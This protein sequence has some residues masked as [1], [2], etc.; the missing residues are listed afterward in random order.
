[1]WHTIATTSQ[2]CFSCK[3]WPPRPDRW[4]CWKQW[5]ATLW[6][7]TM[8]ATHW[9]K[10]RWGESGHWLAVSWASLL[11]RLEP[12]CPQTALF[13]HGRSGMLPGPSVVCLWFEDR[14]HMSW[15]AARSLMVSCA[16]LGNPCLGTS[17]LETIKQIPSG[18]GLLCWENQSIRTATCCLMDSQW[19]SAEVSGVWLR[20]GDPTWFSHQ[21][22]ML[23]MAIQFWL[24]GKDLDVP[25]MP[26]QDNPLY[27]KDAADVLEYA[28][29][30]KRRKEEEFAMSQNDPLALREVQQKKFSV[31]AA[32]M[33]RPEANLASGSGGASSSASVALCWPRS[34]R[35]TDTATGV[36]GDWQ[37]KRLSKYQT[38][39]TSSWG[40]VCKTCQSRRCQEAENQ[41]NQARVWKPLDSSEAQVQWVLHHGWLHHRL[42][43]WWGLQ[44][45]RV[46]EWRRWDQ[47]PRSAL[48]R[49][50]H[51]QRAQLQPWR[52][53]RW[54]SWRWESW[55][56][57]MS[58]KVRSLASSLQ[59]L[60]ETGDSR[61]MTMVLANVS[62]A[63]WGAAG[64]WQESLQTPRGQIRFHLL[65]GHTQATCFTWTIWLWNSL[66]RT[67]MFPTNPFLDARTWRMHFCAWSRKSQ[68]WFSCREVHMW[69]KE[70]F[71]DN[72]WVP[73]SGTYTS[74]VSSSV[75]RWT[76]LSVP[77]SHALQ[78]TILQH[79]WS[80]WKMCST[81]ETRTT[82]KTC[83]WQRWKLNLRWSIHNSVDQVAVWLSWKD[84]SGKLRMGCF[85]F[86]EEMLRRSSRHLRNHL[87]L[88]GSRQSLV[89]T[90]CSWKINLSHWTQGMPALTGALR[91]FASTSAVRG[92][93]WC[94]GS[95]SLRRV[96]FHRPF[97]QRSAWGNWWDIW[98]MLGVWQFYWLLLWEAMDAVQRMSIL[99]GWLK[100]I[101]T[102]TG[103]LTSHTDGP[104]PAACISWIP[105]FCTAVAG[106][107]EQSHFPHVKA[108][109][110]AW[111]LQL[112]M[113]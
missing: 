40:G 30:K 55:F 53:G 26:I 6:H 83:F 90:V 103:A 62:N 1:M 51:G 86:L 20:T 87:E 34:L 91:G 49:P 37:S 2:L 59:S 75:L 41:C 16:S 33:V 106:A 60:S 69:F 21:L 107:K 36:C 78:G 80:M 67:W 105:T 82:G 113:A 8:Q 72:V 101:Q 19:S 57:Q 58:S 10:M 7:M 17:F 4:W 111:F 43:R 63:G 27:D 61:T 28:E 110:I 76:S 85:W 9:Q 15:R 54:L 112:V 23:F 11:R 89:T 44:W 52:M 97:Q 84:R 42:E 92:L 102:L 68:S 29:Q 5:W 104:P 12:S 32:V 71:L 66:L 93:T 65:L 56:L 70:I 64:M 100:R 14:L 46:A 88:Q 45:G 22:Q 79:W 73:N 39:W 18:K 3:G 96:C 81:G 13:G 38:W 77:N 99:S 109:C 48:V 108:N 35:A 50:S 74:E 94:L 95:R 25:P 31:P 24:W 98:S 47:L